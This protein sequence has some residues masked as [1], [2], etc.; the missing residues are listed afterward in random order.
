[1][2]SKG[3]TDLLSITSNLGADFSGT[4][5]QPNGFYTLNLVFAV[6]DELSLFAENYGNFNGDYFDTFLDYS[7]FLSIRLGEI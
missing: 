6:S 3:I 7:S 5:G 1:M 2:A 4:N